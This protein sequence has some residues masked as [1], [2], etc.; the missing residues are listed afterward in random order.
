MGHLQ[1]LNLGPGA[2]NLDAEYLSTNPRIGV[3]ISAPRNGVLGTARLTPLGTLLLLGTLADSDSI[4][5]NDMVVNV[6]IGVEC[7]PGF[8]GSTC[9]TPPPLREYAST[10]YLSTSLP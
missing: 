2:D 6:K 8:T 3:L 10:V 1:T 5:I 9:N 4:Q 7:A